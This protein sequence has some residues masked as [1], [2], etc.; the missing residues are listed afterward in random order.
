MPFCLSAYYLFGQLPPESMKTN[1]CSSKKSGT[2]VGIMDLIRQTRCNL[3]VNTNKRKQIQTNGIKY[4]K[5]Q[6]N[7]SEY[8]QIQEIEA[9]TS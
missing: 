3:K 8:T 1:I 9:N 4:E 7:T 2:Q 5:I 6:T